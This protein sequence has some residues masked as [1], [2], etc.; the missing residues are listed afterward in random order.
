[1]YLNVHIFSVKVFLDFG[2]KRFGITPTPY[3]FWMIRICFAHQNTFGIEKVN[4]LF[5]EGHNLFGLCI[6]PDM[7]FSRYYGLS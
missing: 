3:Y 5:G 7:W 2:F 6:S 1:M 4:V